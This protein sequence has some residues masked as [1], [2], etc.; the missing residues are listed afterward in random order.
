MSHPRTSPRVLGLEYPVGGMAHTSEG[1]AATLSLPSYGTPSRSLL[2]STS[3][4][5]ICLLA[6]KTTAQ[7][8]EQRAP[9]FRCL[10]GFVQNL[11][12][13]NDEV[14]FFAERDGI[15]ATLT[16]DASESLPANGCGLLDV[17]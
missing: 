9:S 2:A 17:L 6:A 16:R 3:L 1:E 7:G 8:Q 10:E 14:L 13:W 15:A 4:A 11:G 12:Q 5:L